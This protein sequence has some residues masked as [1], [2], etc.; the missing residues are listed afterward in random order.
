MESRAIVFI[1]WKKHIKNG[2]WKDLFRCNPQ[3]KLFPAL[4]K[5]YEKKAFFVYA[6]FSKIATNL[7]LQ[8]VQYKH[9][10]D[11]ANDEEKNDEINSHTISP[12]QNSQASKLPASPEPETGDFNEVKGKQR[13]VKI[14][15]F[16][17]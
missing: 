13:H 1:Y 2:L 7:S 10:D 6:K 8:I 12:A 4:K 9:D 3:R 5:S 17:F 14:G 15:K 16:K 11:E